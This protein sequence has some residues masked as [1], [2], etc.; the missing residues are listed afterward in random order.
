MLRR[1]KEKKPTE[2]DEYTA[3]HQYISAKIGGDVELN[4][5][6]LLE[7]AANQNY[8]AKKFEDIIKAMKE[9]Y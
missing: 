7:R 1:K 5:L 3:L 6:I 8:W 4:R 2:A 9:K